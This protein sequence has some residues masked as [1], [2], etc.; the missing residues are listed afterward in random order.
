MS[1]ISGTSGALPGAMVPLASTPAAP[2]SAGGAPPAAGATT[3]HDPAT[4]EGGTA[5][6][7]GAAGVQGGGG[8]AVPGASSLAQALEGLSAA[9]KNLADVVAKMQGGAQVAGVRGTEATEGQQVGNIVA[10]V[11]SGGGEDDDFEQQ[12]LD[13]V[14]AERAKEGLQPLIYNPLLD[15]AAGGHATHMGQVGQMAHEGIGNGTPGDRIRATGVRNAWGE[16]VA[17]GQRTPQQVVAEWMNSPKHRENIMD[18][19]F[20]K[21]GVE[22]VTG[23]DG[24]NYW[25]QEFG[26]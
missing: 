11:I 21:L 15:Q 5:A 9:I 26:A 16:N 18:P 3:Q 2:G 8:P 7:Q 19:T 14:N 22:Q 24:Q 1:G 6:Q 25:A 4:C 23:A 20:T 12:V 17:K 10:P 13:L